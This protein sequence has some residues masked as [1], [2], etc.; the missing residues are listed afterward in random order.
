MGPQRGGKLGTVALLATSGAC[1]PEADKAAF[2]YR[3]ALAKRDIT[4]ERYP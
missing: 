1:A 4:A 2:P 3:D